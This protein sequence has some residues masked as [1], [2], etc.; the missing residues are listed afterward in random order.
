MTDASDNQE[1]FSK[2]AIIAFAI[3]LLAAYNIIF[4]AS[5]SGIDITSV[6]A[7]IC[8]HL[9]R[10]K[11]KK[12]PTLKGRKLANASLIIGY[13]CLVGAIGVIIL[14]VIGL[15]NSPFLYPQF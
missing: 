11:M 3:S 4:R 6:P 10:S 1:R 2:L 14:T 7:I 9:A 5:A 8:A 13:L 15:S 12:D